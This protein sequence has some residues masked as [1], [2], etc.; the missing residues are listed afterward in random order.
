MKGAIGV[1][2]GPLRNW[3]K[4]KLPLEPG[5]RAPTYLELLAT[6][7][8]LRDETSSGGAFS[9]CFRFPSQGGAPPSASVYPSSPIS[10]GRGGSCLHPK[11]LLFT[12][13]RG[14]MQSLASSFPAT[15]KA[16]GLLLTAQAVKGKLSFQSL[17]GQAGSRNSGKDR[18][19]LSAFRTGQEKPEVSSDVNFSLQG[20]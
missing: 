8:W 12:V 4:Q 17:E 19:L 15:K 5:I 3:E 9:H 18:L 2:W 13:V 7:M 16:L 20:R 14:E 11:E 6:S 10:G 1:C